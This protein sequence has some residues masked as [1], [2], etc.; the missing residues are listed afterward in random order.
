MLK[1]KIRFIDNKPFVEINGVSHS[2]LA[3][4]TYFDECGEWSDFIKSGYRMFFVNVSFND[5]PI[6]NIT[7][8]SPFLKGVFESDVP[9]YSDFDEIVKGIISEC[10]DALIFPRIHI[11]MPRKW[12]SE[13]TFETVETL[14]G[15]PRESLFSEKFRCD[16]AELLKE[17]LTHIR[18]ADYSGR[19]AGYQLCG[20]TTQEWIHHDLFGSYSEM[21]MKRFS[22]WC[23]EKHGIRSIRIPEKEDFSKGVIT[24]ETQKY[25]EFCNEEITRTI[26]HF[27]KVTKDFTNNEQIVGVFYGY[28]A[29]VCDCLWGL[30]GL[31]HIIDSPYIDFF[32]S[33]CCYD[34]N[35][36]LGFD[37]GDMIPA[38]SLKLHNKLYFVECDI[39]TNLTRRMQDS[40]P[41]KYPEN[42]Y[43]QYD[44]NGN[45]TAW[46]GPDTL[47]LSLSAIRKAFAHQVTKSSGIWWFDMWGGWYHNSEMM[48]E[49]QKL[50]EIYATAQSKKT[51]NALSAEVALFVDENA[52][53]NIPRGNGLLNLVNHYRVKMGTSG[54]PFDIY[55]VEDAQRV[56]SKY[57][58]AIFTA[59]KPSD[60]GKKAIE[61]CKELNIP[62][63]SAEEDNTFFTTEEIRERL[64]S[65]GVHCYNDGG[66]VVYGGNGILAIHTV[67]D[68]ETKITLPRKMKLSVL[69]GMEATEYYDATISFTAPKHS[70]VIFEIKN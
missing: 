54:I 56:I 31:G 30:H 8:F 36:E 6:N 45:K 25:Y 44:E 33:P 57:K 61:L 21:G 28:N 50:R 10:P 12:V 64:I 37:W 65:F 42:I 46:C 13:N 47:E 43:L 4:T 32:S 22:E 27:S 20:G 48:A 11:S 24:E 18:Y 3:Y 62:Y 23:L 55:M 39:R 35:R 14:N 2:P 69:T 41:G 38:D 49:L 52:Y 19:I 7:G 40:R 26:N 34:C 60:A 68:E 67:T 53:R 59:P 5:L 16:G 15:G 70:T 29:F 51:E 58:G 9:D 17:L 63:I 66:C 1:S